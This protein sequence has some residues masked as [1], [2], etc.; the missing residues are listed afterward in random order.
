M[1]RIKT[2]PKRFKRSPASAPVL[3]VASLNTRIH[4]ILNAGQELKRYS[5]DSNYA[6]P[7]VNT[8]LLAYAN[9]FAGITQGTSSSQRV[10]DSIK[11]EKVS[12]TIRWY[13]NYAS[14]NYSGDLSIDWRTTLLKIPDTTGVAT[15]MTALTL[16]NYTYSGFVSTGVLNDHDNKVVSDKKKTYLPTP[17][18]SGFGA[19]AGG[20]GYKS[21]HSMMTKSFG[22]KGQKINFK[23]GTNQQVEESMILVLAADIPG[24]LTAGSQGT[25]YVAYNVFFRDA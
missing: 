19:L 21:A 20:Q 12:V 18:S 25:F 2:V 24:Y 10:G 9:I 1:A 6:F 16:S 8:N 22:T 14:A 3:S 5:S 4:R 11:V 17:M 23:I 7:A 15:T 13:P